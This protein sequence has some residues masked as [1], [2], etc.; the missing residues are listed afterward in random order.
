MREGSEFCLVPQVCWG[1]EQMHRKGRL[2]FT[3][4]IRLG[5]QVI[6]PNV[7]AEL[8]ERARTLPNTLL[9]I[10]WMLSSMQKKSHW[11]V[12]NSICCI[13][14]SYSLTNLSPITLENVPMMKAVWTS[15]RELIF[16]NMLPCYQE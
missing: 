4:W 12:I 13:T 11:I 8:V 5:D 3:I 6:L 1:P 14:S 9:I 15:S 7:M 10:L 2:R 16:L